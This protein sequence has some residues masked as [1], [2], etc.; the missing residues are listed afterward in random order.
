MTS[1]AD[2]ILSIDDSASE[3]VPVPE[4]DGAKFEVRSTDV[5]QRSAFIDMQISA[6]EAHGED[7]AA[8][9]A[10][11]QVTLVI[12]TAFDPETGQPA[13]TADHAEALKGKNSK[14]VSRLHDVA[15]RLCGLS[16]EAEE[17]AGKGS[18]TTGS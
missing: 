15:M 1:L 2:R 18:E 7:R 12:A 9:L 11:F 17:E 10:D 3:V 16:S 13:F 5:T 4:W 6:N 14:A 8:A